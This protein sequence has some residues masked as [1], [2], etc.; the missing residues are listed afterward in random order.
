MK[1]SKAFRVFVFVAVASVPAVGSPGGALENISQIQVDPT[2]VE[3][4]EK[5]MDPAAADLVR[6]NLRAAVKDAHL[7]EGNSPIRAHI[8]L[9][10]YSTE[11]TA[12]RVMDLGSGRKTA[13]L[14]AN[15][16]IQDASG[17][18]LAN[19]RMHV[20]GSVAFRPVE[21]GGAHGNTFTSDFEQRL[22]KEIEMLK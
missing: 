9:D 14:D 18:E 2:V 19:V 20:H 3:H 11:N 21:G 6:F 4:P 8:V 22:L 17:K 5:I 15:L 1:A 13:T 16:V 10:R 12:R 7:E